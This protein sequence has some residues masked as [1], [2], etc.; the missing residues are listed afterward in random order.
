M[1]EE[2]ILTVKE[3]AEFL[4]VKPNFIYDLKARHA[5]PYHKAGNCLRFFKSEI[6]EWVKNS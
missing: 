5:I 6:I 1:N 3:V 2:E 4:K